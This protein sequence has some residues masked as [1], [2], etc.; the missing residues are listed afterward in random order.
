MQGLPPESEPPAAPPAVQGRRAP[1]WPLLPTCGRLVVV[2]LDA[3]AKEGAEGLLRMAPSVA[4][5]LLDQAARGTR[6]AVPTLDLEPEADDRPSLCEGGLAAAGWPETRVSCRPEPCW[7]TVLCAKH[8]VLSFRC[9]CCDAGRWGCGTVGGRC[10]TALL[11]RTTLQVL[12]QRETSEVAAEG[13]PPWVT[14]GLDGGMPNSCGDDLLIMDSGAAQDNLLL[15][16]SGREPDGE[17]GREI[18]PTSAYASGGTTL[19][20]E[21]TFQPSLS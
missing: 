15:A 19:P 14:S 17:L 20:V 18:S 8:P 16:S 2:V 5:F 10:P 21:R 12:R 1:V 11:G 7:V 4:S 9:T 3:V 13:L 6:A